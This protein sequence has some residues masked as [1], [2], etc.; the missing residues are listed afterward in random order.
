M[1]NLEVWASYLNPSDTVRLLLTKTPPRDTY[2]ARSSAISIELWLQVN[3]WSPTIIR[4]IIAFLSGIILCRYLTAGKTKVS[5]PNCSF[6]TVFPS[7]S[8]SLLRT[9][10]LI[11][12]PRSTRMSDCYTIEEIEFVFFMC[13]LAPLNHYAK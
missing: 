4:W 9:L 8:P 5:I 6:P 7:L 3:F 1:E 12:S 11:S 13:W 10:L 2:G